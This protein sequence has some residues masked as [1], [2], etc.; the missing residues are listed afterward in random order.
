LD[1]L[2]TYRDAGIGPD[3][4]PISVKDCLRALEKAMKASWYSYSSFNMQKFNSMLRKG[5][6]SWIVPGKIIAFPSPVS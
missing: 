3:D 5:D 1:N 2:K 4:Y 6:L